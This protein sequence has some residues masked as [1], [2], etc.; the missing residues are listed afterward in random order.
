MLACCRRRPVP[1]VS[2]GMVAV[3]AGMVSVPVVTGTVTRVGAT[4]NSR[5]GA[6]AMMLV[7]CREVKP[8]QED[9]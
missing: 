9:D 3:V 8:P 2:V 4:S 7:V 5:A 6:A 1:L